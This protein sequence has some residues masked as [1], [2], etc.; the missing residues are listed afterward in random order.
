MLE[1]TDQ[2]LLVPYADSAT[3][4]LRTPPHNIHA[5]QSLLGGLMLDNSTWD[6]IADMVVERDLYR[7]EHRLV[8]RA[9]AKLAEADQPFDVVT[10]AETLERTQQLEPAGG[11]SY[12]G[13]LVNETPSAANIKA[14]AKIVRETSVL[15]QMIAA[16]TDIADSGYNPGGR[17]ASELLDAAEQRVFEIAE[18]ESR[19]G[20]GFQP[21]KTL[22]TR[23]VERIDDLYRRDEPITGLSTGFTDFDM[24]TSGLQP[25]DLII[26]AGRPSM[27]KC[28][29]AGT[30]VLLADGSLETIETVVQRRQ[31]R[32]LTLGDDWRLHQTQPSAYVDD[33]MKPV[34]R[35]T[36]RLGREIETTAS[37]PYLTATGW[38]PLLELAPGEAVAVPRRL[39]VF[40][41]TP[42]RDCEVRLLGY[43]L[44]DGGL[45]AGSPKLTNAD[46]RIQADFVA[47]VGAFG[48]VCAVIRERAARTTDITVAADRV[49]L[50][51]CRVRFGQALKETITRLGWS[52]R[53]LALELGASPASV[54][55]WT[56]GRAM[57]NATLF[58]G[59]SRL[60]PDAVAAWVPQGRDSAAKNAPNALTRWLDGLGL[61]GRDAHGKFVPE[62]VFRLPKDQVA[63]FLNRL[64]ATDGWAT[65]LATGQSQLGYATVSDRLGRQVQHLLLRFGIIAKRRLRQIKGPNGPARCWQ[66]DITDSRSIKTFL[67]EIGIFSKETALERVRQG[68]EGR[69][70]QTNRDLIPLAFWDA[71]AAAKGDEPWRCLAERAGID[72]ASNIHVGRRALTRTRLAQLAG[73][74]GDRRLQD[75]AASDLYWDEIVAIEPIGLRQVYD[76]TIPDTHNFIANDVCVHNTSFAMNLAEHAAIQGRYPVAVFSME[77]PGD[78]LAMRMMASLGR[79]DSHRVRT[80]KLED[81]EWPRLTSAVNI[82]AGA[83]LFIDDT[84]ALS[85]TELRARARRLKREQ[86]GLGLVVIDYL[87][88]MQAPGSNENRTTEIS[89]I[90][91]SLKALAKELSVPVVALS[92]LNRSLEQRPNKRPVM[93]D[94]RE[95]VTGDTLVVL[96]DGRRVPIQDLVGSTAEVI[97]VDAQG[98]L[99]RAVSDRIWA[100]GRRPVQRV[101]LA[102]GRCIRATAEHRL[103]ADG[104]WKTVGQLAAGDRL[105]LAR[106]LPE[107]GVPAVDRANA[108]VEPLFDQGVIEQAPSNRS[109]DQVSA[110][111]PAGE[112]DVYDLTVPGPESWLADGIVSHNSGAIEQD[113]DLIVFIYRDEVYNVESKDKG[114]AEIIIGKQRNGPIGTLRL[115]FLGKYTKFENYTDNYYGEEMH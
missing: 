101:R 7:R 24:M 27:G 61:W 73:A 86:G 75:L 82:L 34:F 41:D 20:V 108:A 31:A 8:F 96:A 72:G 40:G 104:G 50:R 64:F 13:T 74:L 2:E 106:C 83:S 30:E 59:I 15:R 10:L 33:G 115:A 80:G 56:Q 9:I 77:M 114:V 52:Q 23:A 4:S 54:C 76:L 93:S 21:I 60:F 11:L 85:P 97:A 102:S 87:Q 16:G 88:L 90:S 46:P 111:E 58:E 113:A 66:L 26:V 38:R 78:A 3:D 99:V 67:A 18:Q 68:L 94:L 32:L 37:H 84:P 45:T 81:D 65:V 51:E 25:S 69:R 6:R 109:W 5:E 42:M 28:V 55:N 49:D 63:L 47:A 14:Y 39:P 35:V 29:E 89:A 57:P 107:P 103:F 12:L 98:K 22:L 19:G 95:C 43:L 71:I 1:P 110:I 100:V 70:A 44:G 62:G 17:E 36:T 53:D 48:G 91:R 105:A 92:Q 79:I 112:D